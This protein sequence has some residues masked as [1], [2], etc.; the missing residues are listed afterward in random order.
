MQMKGNRY[1]LHES[2]DQA[3]SWQRPCVI[4]LLK[5][6]RVERIVGDQCQ[7]GQQSH[8]GDPIKKPTG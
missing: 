3:A 5:D 8:L 4:E 2:P 6:E 7:F 1:F